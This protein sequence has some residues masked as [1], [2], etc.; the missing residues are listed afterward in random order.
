MCVTN[1][2]QLLHKLLP[3]LK[4]LPKY[5]L[6]YYCNLQMNTRKEMMINPSL[7]LAFPHLVYY[8]LQMPSLSLVCF[9]LA[10][11]LNQPIYLCLWAFSFSYFCNH[12]FTLTL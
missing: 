6:I 5:N 8:H 10:F 4:C 12:T 3:N 11:N 2:A 7:F 9:L 1:L